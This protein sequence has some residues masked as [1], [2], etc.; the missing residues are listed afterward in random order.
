M[1]STEEKLLFSSLLV[2]SLIAT[3][4]SRGAFYTPP[5]VPS[6][7]NRFDR[8]SINQ[9]YSESFGH[10]NIRI[11]NNGSN[12][13]LILDKSSGKYF[14]KNSFKIDHWNL[15]FTVCFTGSNIANCLAGSGLV[16]RSKYNYG[17][18]SAAIKLPSGFT[19]GVVIAFYV[20]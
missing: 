10:S 15:A 20:S 16:S 19:S 6:L 4:S 14:P 1:A 18:F 5:T 12:A 11:L 13:N 7:T 9:G 17:F 2:F 3:V 8:V